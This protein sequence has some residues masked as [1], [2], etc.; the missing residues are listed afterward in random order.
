MREV[1]HGAGTVKEPQAVWHHC[2]VRRTRAHSAGV[3]LG[4]KPEPAVSVQDTTRAAKTAW[5]RATGPPGRPGAW[6]V[7]RGLPPKRVVPR[8]AQ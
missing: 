5:G 6:M 3:L 7:W 4:V 1:M 2:P 8:P